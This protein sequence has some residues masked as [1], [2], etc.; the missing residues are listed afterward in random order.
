MAAE[1]LLERNDIRQRSHAGFVGFEHARF[2]YP[3]LDRRVLEFA[4]AVDGRFK[5]REGRGRRLL[6]LGMQGLVPAEI[7]ARSDKV[8]FCPDYHLR[9]ERVRAAAAERLK[10]FAGA[11]ELGGIVDF[12]KVLRALETPPVY[13]RSDPMRVD[14]DSQFLV[15]N[16][17]YLCYFLT[18][19]GT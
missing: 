19:F 14:Y 18:R 16:A 3:F 11:G 17:V 8:P 1:I 12:G 5:Q 13:R 15:P 6:R 2:C 7:L 4:L 9:Y 10:T